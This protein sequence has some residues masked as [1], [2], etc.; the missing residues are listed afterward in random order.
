MTPAPKSGTTTK[1]RNYKPKNP[2]GPD[3]AVIGWRED[4]LFR[5]LVF[6]PIGVFS[7]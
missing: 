2:P 5:T 7:F 4:E 3:Q 6:L 1:K